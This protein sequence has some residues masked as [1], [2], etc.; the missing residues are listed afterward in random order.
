MIYNDMY[1]YVYSDSSKDR[2]QYIQLLYIS[3]WILIDKLLLIPACQVVVIQLQPTVHSG[4]PSTCADND[5]WLGL[6]VN[7]RSACL[8]HSSILRVWTVAPWVPL[9]AAFTDRLS[10]TFGACPPAR[11]F[12]GLKKNKRK[13]CRLRTAAFVRFG[14]VFA[15]QHCPLYSDHQRGM[16]CSVWFP[17]LVRC[18]T[19]G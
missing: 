8:G 5:H 14:S 12:S 18:C 4:L 13:T 3:V 16:D 9:R 15:S 19:G 10:L 7:A 17:D 2:S 1:F 11:C 6:A